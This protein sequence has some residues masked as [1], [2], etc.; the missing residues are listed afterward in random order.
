[1]IMAISS[2]PYVRYLR[3]A[4]MLLANVQNKCNGPTYLGG[5]LGL[6]VMTGLFQNGCYDNF[7]LVIQH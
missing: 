2:P 6:R 4:N 3:P 5:S 7:I 1:M